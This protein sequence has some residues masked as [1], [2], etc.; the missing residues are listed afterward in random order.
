MYVGYIYRHGNRSLSV[1][2]IADAL[3]ADLQ[4]ILND[5]LRRELMKKA[6][7]LVHDLTIQT[8][9][10]FPFETDGTTDCAISDRDRNDERWS[11]NWAKV[12]SFFFEKQKHCSWGN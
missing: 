3:P 4:S 6:D 10:P 9:R 2:H 7:G 8:K 11:V 5:R 12:C 1:I